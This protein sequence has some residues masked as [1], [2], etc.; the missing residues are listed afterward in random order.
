MKLNSN[1]QNLILILTDPRPNEI[2]PTI[3]VEDHSNGERSSTTLDVVSNYGASD[4]SVTCT[5]TLPYLP[6][7]F[8]LIWKK[9][10]GKSLPS[11]VIQKYVAGTRNSILK[12]NR[13]VVYTDAGEY[14]CGRGPTFPV[15]KVNL[16][17]TR[18]CEVAIISYNYPTHACAAG[19]K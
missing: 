3:V 5:T 16:I 7:P 2:V 4:F 12:W 10:N 11:G 1:P 13:S 9:S 15:A 19:V 8:S 17:V 18:E 6:N 14:Q